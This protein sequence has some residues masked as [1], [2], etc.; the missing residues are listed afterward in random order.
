MDV[1]LAEA[2]FCPGPENGSSYQ[3]PWAKWDCT[4]NGH[5]LFG[6]SCACSKETS[7]PFSQSSWEEL[8]P[9]F[10]GN[11]LCTRIAAL[12]GS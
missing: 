8:V 11:S 7:L 4:G 9:E 3:E 12:N 1:R 5:L 6:C 2:C 10:F